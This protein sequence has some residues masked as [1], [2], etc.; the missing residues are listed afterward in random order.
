MADYAPQKH[1][2]DDAINVAEAMQG[3]TEYDTPD[4][5]HILRIHYI[6]DPRKRTRNG[7]RER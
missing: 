1:V 7:R 2:P 3:I 5:F 6:A 4:G